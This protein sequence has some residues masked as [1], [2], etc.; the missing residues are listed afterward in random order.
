MLFFR[1]YFEI[2]FLE[3]ESTFTD[4]RK[5]RLISDSL[6]L[7]QVGLFNTAIQN[8]EIILNKPFDYIGSLSYINRYKA[9]KDAYEREH[10]GDL[11]QTQREI[12]RE[13]QRKR[14]P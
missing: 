1:K 7:I 6:D 12:L 10:A 2:R 14:R 4:A 13:K 3:E 8:F 9:A 11:R 5:E